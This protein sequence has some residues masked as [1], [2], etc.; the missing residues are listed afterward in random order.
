M[1][2]IAVTPAELAAAAGSLERAAGDVA[3]VGVRSMR[4]TGAGD[5]GS[6]ELEQAVTELCQSSFAVVFALWNAV[7]ATGANLAAAGQAYDTVDSR[8][9]RPGGG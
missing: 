1:S 5:L 2:S 8:S 6:P 4:G 9:M 7:S 3:T